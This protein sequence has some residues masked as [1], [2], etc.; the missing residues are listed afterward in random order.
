[1]KEQTSNNRLKD[2][3]EKHCRENVVD[4]EL[5]DEVRKAWYITTVS[6]LLLEDKEIS[7]EVFRTQLN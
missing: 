1:M 3:A 6:K 5:L 4:F 7:K 2:I